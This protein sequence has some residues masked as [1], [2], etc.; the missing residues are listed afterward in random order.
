MK[1]LQVLPTLSAGGAESF[2]ANLCIALAQA[3]VEPQLHLLSTVRDERGKL[4]YERLRDGGV[5]VSGNTYDSIRNWQVPIEF[6]R[7]ANAFRPNYIQANLHSSE[8]IVAATKQFIRSKPK[9]VRRLANSRSLGLSSRPVLRWLDRRFDLTVAC[10]ETVHDYYER[11]LKASHD[12]DIVTILNGS[13]LRHAPPTDAE[14]AAA[15][16]ALGINSEARVFANIGAMRPVSRADSSLESAQKAHDVLIAAFS[17]AFA[18]APSA[19][20]LLVGDGQLRGPLESLAASLGIANQVRFLGMLP[21]PWLALEAADIFVF[22]SRFE[23]HPNVLPE[24]ISCGLPLLISDIRENREMLYGAPH[25]AV[26]VDDVDALASAMVELDGVFQSLKAQATA[27]AQIVF[28]EKSMDRCAA[29]YISAFGSIGPQ[30]NI[31]PRIA[32]ESC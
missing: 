13:V 20:L 6:L 10:S 14:K 21:E 25:R 7:E 2:V 19:I 24:A 32:N 27:T 16:A 5:H 26:A 17:R 30:P 29:A 18:A 8:L 9:L 15:R 3:G 1:V 11:E 22:P 31:S 28:E 23:G 4:L 12:C